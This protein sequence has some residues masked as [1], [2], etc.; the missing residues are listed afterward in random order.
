M[1]PLIVIARKE[2]SE[3]LSW[4]FAPGWYK[5][6]R[7]RLFND[8]KFKVSSRFEIGP[9]ARVHINLGL[10]PRKEKIQVLRAESPIHRSAYLS[11]PNFP[12]SGFWLAM[13]KRDGVDLNC[14][15]LY[16][17]PTESNGR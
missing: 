8:S 16:K 3:T 12:P 17:G 7:W 10:R 1:C 14:L 13:T 4:G 5:T 11:Y 9:K 6:R 2:P 15:C